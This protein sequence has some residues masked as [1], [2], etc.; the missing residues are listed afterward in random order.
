VRSSAIYLNVRI[1]PS[2][3]WAAEITHV[4]DCP[5]LDTFETVELAARAFDATVWRMDGPRGPLNFLEMESC[6][7]AKFLAPPFN[8]VR[9][10]E[11]RV[12]H[13]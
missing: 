2:G 11:D 10:D 8:F 6:K 3:R 13:R 1:R 9:R 7:E 4:G 12:V 5:C